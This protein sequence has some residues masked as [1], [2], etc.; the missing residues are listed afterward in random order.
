M[1]K[2]LMTGLAIA[3]LG[4]GGAVHSDPFSTAASVQTETGINPLLAEVK[5]GDSKRI[6]YELE[7]VAYF[8][9][10]PITAK[11]TFDVA[12]NPDF[13]TINTHVK[14]TGVADIFVD[15]DMTVA[16]S[17]YVRDN[18]LMTYNYVSQN[19]DGKKNRRVE[20]TYGQDDV[21]M[22]AK[23]GFG[24]LGFPPA[25]PE[26]KIEARDPLT[27]FIG[28]AFR[29]RPADN[30]CGG[31]IKFFD[32]KQLTYMSFTPIGETSVRTKAYKGKAF[33]CHVTV[34]RVAGY[35]E[36]DRGTNLS[37]ID[38]PM[39]MFF[40]EPFDGFVTPVKLIV[41]SEDVGKITVTAKKLDLI[42]AG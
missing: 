30:P 12:L 10:I 40:A 18:D 4:L 1:K 41:D 29:P 24:D 11:G 5:A 2:T 20:L 38:G 22:V 39:R 28:A 3:A 9:F 35:D 25:T 26:Q 17:G 15:Y 16:A 21:K 27:A 31:Q 23:P 13:Y 32:G 14:T 34:N 19:H 33:E 37:G 42:D 6:Q 8:L 7:A 36:D